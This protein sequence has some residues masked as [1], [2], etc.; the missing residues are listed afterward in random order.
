MFAVC[1]FPELAGISFFC[2]SPPPPLCS[3]VEAPQ[4]PTGCHIP[5][6]CGPFYKPATIYFTHFNQW[7][8]SF[9]F[10]WVPFQQSLKISCLLNL[11]F[12]CWL[13]LSLSREKKNHFSTA[14]SLKRWISNA[15]TYCNSNTNS[16]L[17]LPLMPSRCQS[18]PLSVTLSRAGQPP[19]DSWNKLA[20]YSEWSGH[21]LT[22]E[23]D[24]VLYRKNWWKKTKKSWSAWGWLLNRILHKIQMLR[25]KRIRKPAIKNP[26]PKKT[27]TQNPPNPHFTILSHMFWWYCWVKDLYET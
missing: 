22:K 8:C 5:S 26:K 2:S 16:N 7:F 10:H 27:H 21:R 3:N 11:K 19:S 1:L 6:S 24:F 14:C 9:I 4:P 15:G 17:C 13:A 18:C 12:H 25:L 20:V 23:P